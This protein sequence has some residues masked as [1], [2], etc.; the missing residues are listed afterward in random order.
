MTG[1]QKFL[2]RWSRL[3]RADRA[4]RQRPSQPPATPPDPKRADPP[5]VASSERGQPPQSGSEPASLA[6]TA[7]PALQSIVANTDI[8]AF[9]RAGVPAELTKAAL[10]RAW[11]A[12]PAIRDFIGIAENQWDFTNPGAIPGFGALAPNEDLGRLVA[13]ALGQGPASPA[14]GSLAGSGE[15]AATVPQDVP[16]VYGIPER[17]D[18][19]EQQNQIVEE[20]Q[21]TVLAATQHHEPAAEPERPLSRRSHGRALPK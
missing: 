12:D 18:A 15:A 3:K 20:Q 11:T 21:K 2:R 7:L 9:L 14:A 10:R 1:S 8:R 13:Q 16:Q 17:N 5:A 19:A 6:E 4:E